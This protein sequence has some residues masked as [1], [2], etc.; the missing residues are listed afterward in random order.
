M[1]N[2]SGLYT[3]TTQGTSVIQAQSGAITATATITVTNG[4][5]TVATVAAATP[6]PV[7]GTTTNLSVLGA[8]DVDTSVLIYT[9]STVGTAPAPVTFNTNGDNA[10]KNSVATFTKAGVYTLRVTIA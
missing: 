3:A 2:G 9:W 1:I 5:P 4:I 10:A 8:D 6:S 7:N